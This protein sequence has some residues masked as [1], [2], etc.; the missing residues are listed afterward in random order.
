VFDGFGPAEPNEGSALRRVV[1]TLGTSAYGFGRLIERLIK[2]L[3]VDA[4]VLWQTGHTDVSPFDIE[5]TPFL[6]SADLA[7]AM[8]AADLVVA[9]AGVGSA[10]A[11]LHSG[12]SPILVPRRKRYAEHVDDHQVQI[13]RRLMERGI[14]FECDASDLTLALAERAASSRARTVEAPPYALVG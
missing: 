3:P 4:E 7:R 14:A 9:H 10:L 11:A 5:A 8:Q 1:V 2:I 6:P 12:H 13:G